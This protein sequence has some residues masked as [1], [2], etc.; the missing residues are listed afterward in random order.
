MSVTV[1]KSVKLASS[2]S[3]TSS[4]GDT[5]VEPPNGGGDVASEPSQHAV[6]IEPG[7]LESG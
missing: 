5:L 4:T 6:G 3:S 7:A 2:A 1:T